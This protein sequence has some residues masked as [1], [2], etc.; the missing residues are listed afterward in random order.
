MALPCKLSCAVSLVFIVAM[1]YMMYATNQS[2]IIGDYEKTLSKEL[3]PVYKKIAQ[4][5]TSIY[6]YGYFQNG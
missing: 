3:L 1:I 6:Y 4:E 2:N 5:R